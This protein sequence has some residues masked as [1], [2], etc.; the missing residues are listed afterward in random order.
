MRHLPILLTYI[1]ASL[2]LPGAAHPLYGS[3]KSKEVIS[4]QEKSNKKNVKSQEKIDT[5]S[6][7]KQSL[8]DQYRVTLREISNL[9][10]Y[11]KQ[12]TEMIASQKEEMSSIKEQIAGIDETHKSLI[13]LMNEMVTTLRQF[14][15][16]DIP[17]LPGERNERVTNLEKLLKR[18]DV[19]TSEK[20]RRIL[21]AYQV[22]VEYGNTIESY[23]DAVIYKGKKK[24]VQLLKVGRVG[25]YFQSLDGSEVAAWDKSSKDWVT[26]EDSYKSKISKAIKIAKKHIAPDLLEL[27][28]SSPEAS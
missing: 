22:E 23:T 21:E 12:M 3:T 28:I 15:S 27:P 13:P 8:L 10:A 19:S 9:K 26:L 11:N 2:L 18:A 14:V 4:V 16:M 7:E 5:L 6:D 20:Y 17:F 24:T 25:F 1:V